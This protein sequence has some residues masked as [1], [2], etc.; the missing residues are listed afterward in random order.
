MTAQSTLRKQPSRACKVAKTIEKKGSR[1]AGLPEILALRIF[2]F[3]DDTAILSTTLNQYVKE[4]WPF[5]VKRSDYR[6]VCKVCFNPIKVGTFIALHG[7]VEHPY[8]EQHIDAIARGSP[9]NT[10]QFTSA[11]SPLQKGIKFIPGTHMWVHAAC[12]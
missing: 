2:S 5:F 4:E 8:A 9:I 7:N 10:N 3:L 11:S 12:R 1:Y 6:D